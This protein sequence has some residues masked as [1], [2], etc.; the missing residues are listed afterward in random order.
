MTRVTG[1][2]LLGVL[3]LTAAY[4]LTGRLGL[5]LAVPPGYATAIF[6]PAGL[7]VSAMLIA[8]AATLPATFLGSLLLNLWVAYSL[9]HRLTGVGVATAL[10]IAAA[11]VLQ[12]AIGGSVLRRAIGYPAALDNARD[13]LRFLVISP[14]ACLTSATLSLAGMWALGAVEAAEFPTSWLTWW[15]GD[16][17]ALLVVLPLMLVFFGKPRAL[18][19]RRAPYVALP[20]ALFFA[21]FVAIFARVSSWEDDQALLEF[22]LRSQ[23]L[24]DML[25]ASLEEEGVFLEQLGESFVGR[26]QAITPADFKEL[27]HKLVQRFPTIQAVEWAPRVTAAEREAFEAAQR[28][29]FPGFVIRERDP[30]GP[31]RPAA[32]R[33][34]FYPVTYL[35]PVAGNQEAIGF[36]LASTSERR[37]A[38]ET[39]LASGQVAASAPV[40]LVQERGEQAGVL[41]TYAVPSG[42]TGQGI[43]L[44][45]LRMGTFTER[46][47]GSLRSIM[48]VRFVDAAGTRPLFD[49]SAATEAT[50]PFETA[51]D[52][53]T[54]RYV[55]QTEPGALYLT[56]HRGWESWI[57]LAA[58]VFST[59]LL[60]ALLMLG[61]GQAHRAERLVEERTHELQISN[62][63]LTAEIAE[64]ERTE[65]AL[66]QA[67][68]M[69]AIGQL[70]GGIAH[71]FNNLLTVV[72]GSLELLGRHVVDAAGKRL[73]T[74]AQG[75]AERGARLTHSLLSFARRQALRPEIVDPSRLVEEFGELMRRAVG[76]TIELRLL[77]TPAPG[78]CSIDPAQ[79]QAA[80]LN[81]VVNARDAM[82]DGGVLII[83]TRNVDLDAGRLANGET[84]SGRYVAISVRDTGCGMTSDVRERAFEPFYTTK[85]VGTGSGLGLSQV[86]GFVK[87]S[88]GQVEI[89]SEFGAG[90]T[91]SLYLPR[92]GDAAAAAV[93]PS[94]R[95][96]KGVGTA[97][98]E[99]ILVVEDDADVRSVVADELRALGYRVVTAADGPAA[100]MILDGG[101]SVD[102]LFSDVVMPNRMRG[103]ELARRATAD[104]PGLK[105]LLTSGY[106]AGSRDGAPPGEFALL[107]KPY[108]HDELARVVR[109]ALEAQNPNEPLRGDS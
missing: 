63:R 85:E 94:G 69:E 99:T 37:A 72:A 103:D 71:D 21:L 10:V 12:A 79:F 50:E 101:E 88:G 90:T 42:A 58:G 51:F 24:A 20:M 76:E 30:A 92:I 98:T 40:R 32:A 91:V 13:L 59:G 36:D 49:D 106:T 107:R 75:G 66:Q 73:L 97:G 67:Q 4:V 16:T 39:T 65:S 38:I 18:W 22:R 27:V 64:R 95:T 11:S 78:S 54:R 8:G 74:A 23:H 57:V 43:V 80:L 84:G 82:P 29:E 60:G 56:T 70:T 9:A 93:A 46:L 5:L 48:T 100:L 47:L 102:L 2:L 34:Q 3:A 55:L 44:V 28:K 83:E 53:G 96:R 62:Q 6:P 26:H 15:I 108:R 105:V 89:S 14:A 45:A 41:L 109:T 61:T 1:R 86:Y 7:A 31:L 77:L 87:Q 33:A 81:L 17:L 52:F 35:E 104:R 19:R 25:Q 68:R